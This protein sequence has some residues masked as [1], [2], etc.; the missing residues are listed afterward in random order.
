VKA[1]ILVATGASCK[2]VVALAA[3]E[4]RIFLPDSLLHIG[5]RET[6]Q[7]DIF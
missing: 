4:A 1:A 7:L 2:S 3:I 5:Q 6:A